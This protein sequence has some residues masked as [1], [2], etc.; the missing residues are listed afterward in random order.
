M[1]VRRVW[2]RTYAVPA[3]MSAVALTQFS[4]AH[5][6]TLSPWK[7]AG[8]GMFSTV[9]SPGAR[10][11]RIALIT[12]KG[13]IPVPLP[14]EL[15]PLA[16]QEKTWPT[17]SRLRQIAQRLSAG[18]WTPVVLRSASGEYRNLLARHQDPAVTDRPDDAVIFFNI[19]RMQSTGDPPSPYGVPFS[20]VRVEL[21]KAEFDSPSRQYAA[22]KLYA[23]T[24][25]A[26]A[27]PQMRPV[28][29]AM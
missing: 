1:I 27:H 7:G 29:A 14:K 16:A 3:L 5:L 6:H 4:L 17:D 13:T 21:W 12:P 28:A 26:T 2:L 20:A 24:V 9:D 11:L 18:T 10:F 19:L 15:A 23:I 8:F 22:R 25:P